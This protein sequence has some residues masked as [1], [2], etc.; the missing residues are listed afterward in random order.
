MTHNH[1]TM[2]TAQYETLCSLSEYILPADERS[3]SAREAGVPEFLRFLHSNSTAYRDYLHEG[4]AWLDTYCLKKTGRRFIEAPCSSQR[5]ILNEIAVRSESP[6]EELGHGIT[7]FAA[8]RKDVLSAFFTSQ[9]GIRDL[10]YQGN[11]ALAQSPVCP[12]LRRQQRSE[13]G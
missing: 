13:H 7:F 1:P 12:P 11:V 8:L 9:I 10:E 4:L 6:T 2:S 3:C 5:A